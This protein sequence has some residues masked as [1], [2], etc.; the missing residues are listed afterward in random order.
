MGGHRPAGLRVGQ[1]EP[2][3]RRPVS[4]AGRHDLQDLRDVPD[5]P[6]AVVAAADVDD[7]VDGHAHENVDGPLGQCQAAAQAEDEDPVE[8]LR[9]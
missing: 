6:G 7:Q 3:D 8:R 9:R 5:R 2:V 1:E 4:V